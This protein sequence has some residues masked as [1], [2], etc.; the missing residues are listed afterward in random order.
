MGRWHAPSQEADSQLG[1]TDGETEK[2]FIA[3]VVKALLSLME[4]RGKDNRA[5]AASNMMHVFSQYPRFLKATWKLLRTVVNK[6]FEYM[7]ELHEG[8]S[9]IQRCL[10]P[11]A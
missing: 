2:G 10:I 6:L 4:M 11:S 1:V 3:G 9:I 7:H 5:V 8:K